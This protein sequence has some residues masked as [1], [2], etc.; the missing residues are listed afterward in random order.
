MARELEF[1]R[2]VLEI[3][4]QI[5]ELRRMAV[6]RD[7]LANVVAIDDGAPRNGKDSRQLHRQIRKLEERA[8]KL[9]AQVFSRLSRWQ[10]VQVAR[11]PERP[12]TLDYVNALC[13]D[14]V[15]LHGD[16]RFAEDPAIVAGLAR[17]RGVPV[18]VMGHQK[19]RSTRENME[20]NFG[21]PRPEGY[22][23][24]TRL[25]RMADQFGLPILS[26]IDTPGAYPGLGAEERGQAQA[27]A[28]ALETFALLRVPVI[29]TVIGE[30]GSGGAL[31][32]GVANRILILEF[33]IYS[34][35]SP[36]GCASILFKDSAHAARAADALKLTAPDLL[37]LGV[38]DAVVPEPAGG[39][40]RDPAE[41]AQALGDALW[42]QLQ[43]LRRAGPDALRDD[44]YRRFRFL[45]AFEGDAAGLPSLMAKADEADRAVESELASPSTADILAEGS[46]ADPPPEPK[47]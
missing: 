18:M 29:A 23:K 42:T 27:I 20:R 5:E 2:P 33:G 40:H 31:A 11:H 25:A 46:T 28:E 9:K 16:R 14:F 35:I 12:F 24:A 8:H 36:E 39:A 1:E 3:E 41:A 21:M 45:G 13:T 43:G 32:I 4:R 37:S 44:R 38:V 30:G 17:F 6:G 7:A 15:E 47:S 22:R 26:F 10:I 19:G 34:V